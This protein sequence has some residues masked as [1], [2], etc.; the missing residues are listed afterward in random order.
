MATIII[1]TPPPTK[2]PKREAASL[3]Q[4][5]VTVLNVDILE[6]ASDAEILYAALST[7][8]IEDDTPPGPGNPTNPTE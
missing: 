5:R 4:P 1:I 2:P 3:E 7:L 8:G 6:D